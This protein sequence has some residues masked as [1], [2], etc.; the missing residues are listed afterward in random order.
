M[1]RQHDPLRLDVAAFA[2]DGAA[3]DGQWPGASLER[4]AD[5]QTPPQDVPLAEVRWQAAGE[6]RPV[7]GGEAEL[8]LSLSADTRVWLT[9]QRCLQPFEVP[10]SLSRRI[11]FVRGESQAEALDAESEDDVLALSRSLDLR[12]LVEDE[13]LLDLPIV[14]RHAVCPQP[15]PTGSPA[16]EAGEA[17]SPRENPFAVLR[18][19]KTGRNGD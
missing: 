16:D 4:L 14:P 6:R 15:L 2:A 5:T 19:L 13:L 8:W 1:K 11:R 10:L 3:L 17:A 12:E 18:Q 7:T 9:C